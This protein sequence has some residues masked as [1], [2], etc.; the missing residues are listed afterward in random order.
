MSAASRMNIAIAI[1]V[2]AVIIAAAGLALPG[3]KGDTGP[4][5]PAGQAGSQGA[6]G[7]QGQTGPAGPQ[8]PAG[9]QGAQGPAG[10]AG[11]AGPQ[12]SAGAQ[13]PAG[14]A[15]PQGP[16]GAQGAL[17]PAGPAGAAGV[18]VESSIL[19]ASPTVATPSLDGA[20]DPVWLKATPLVV[21]V[22]NGANL[23]NGSTTVL[24]RALY[25][26]D[27]IYFLAQWSDPTLSQRRSPW[28]MQ[29]DG[30]WKKLTD[31]NDKGGDNNLYYED[32][33]SFIWPTNTGVKGFE[34][35]G[36]LAS[37]HPG[38]TK[39]YGNMY[40]SNAG[41]IADMWHFKSIRTAPNGQVD[42]QYLDSTR[43]NKT[44]APEAGRHSDPKTSGG[45][46]DNVNAAKNGPQYGRANNMPAPPYYILDSEKVPIN[47]SNY[48]A[49]DEVPGIIIAPIVGDRGDIKVGSVWKDGIWTIEMSRKLVT[50]SKYDVQYSNM[51]AEYLFGVAVFENAAV[52]HAWTDIPLKLTFQ[53]AETTTAAG[54]PAIP[55]SHEGRTTCAVCHATGAAG[56]PI[57]PSTPD[58]KSFEDARAVCS[59]CHG[60]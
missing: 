29:A 12:G 49:G 54:I 59:T 7:A 30:T 32:K 42:D 3:Q 40:T 17:G 8:G 6:A 38:E 15:G 20:V 47:A 46:N 41:E 26:K 60:K 19:K 35:V 11:S 43:Y 50:G 36:C 28:Q 24:M 1:A 45:Y 18:G 2:I 57:F 39:P 4:A 13:G 5:G 25:T 56:A 22:K 33:A 21:Q 14:S 37:C 9:A 27:T 51:T 44:S 58:H 23:P 53:T 34:K 10:P 16:Q 52:R 55:A 48:K 31:P